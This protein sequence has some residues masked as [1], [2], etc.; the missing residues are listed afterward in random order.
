MSGATDAA[1]RYP[2]RAVARLTGLAI[3]TLRAWERRYEAVT[4]ARDD[5]GRLYTE[6]EIARLRLLRAAVENGH[7]I[8]RIAG[9]ADEALAQLAAPPV[10]APPAP[11]DHQPRRPLDRTVLDDALRRFDAAALDQEIGRL[12]VMLRPLALVQDVLMPLLVRVGDDWQAGRGGVAHEHLM[13]AAVRN[14]LGSILRLYARPDAPT[15]LLFATLSGDRHEIGTLGAAMLAASSGA[16]VAY[17]GPDLPAA[18]IVASV[19][20]AV[21]RVVVLGITAGATARTVDREL[22]TLVRNLPEGVELW[23]GGSG[24]ASRAALIERRGLVLQ[25]YDAYQR[26]LARVYGLRT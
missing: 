13:V 12:A 8:G 18:D 3:D 4:P 14:V 10:A 20:P 25:D 17:L 2:I 26:E 7:G 21:A 15:R 6:A 11:A 16:G 1:A 24:A 23:V 22:R 9:L 5:R 19:R